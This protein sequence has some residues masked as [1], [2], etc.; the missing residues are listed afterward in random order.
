META[1]DKKLAGELIKTL[2][3]FK[4]QRLPHE[5][6]WQEQAEYLLP[7]REILMR[8]S[9]AKGMST[10]S[11]VFDGIGSHVVQVCAD[12]ILGYMASPV[13]KWNRSQVGR[14]PGV[15][16]LNDIP[17]IKKY[18]QEYDEAM[19][20]E[21]KNSGGNCGGFYQALGVLLRDGISIG[22][23][24]CFTTEHSKK[25]KLLY[26]VFH[27]IE[28]YIGVN[29]DGEVDMILREYD[30]SNRNALKYFGEAKLSPECVQAAK[31][32]PLKEFKILWII[33]PREERIEGLKSAKHMPFAAYYVDIKNSSILG[34]SG[35]ETMPIVAYRCILDS[36]ETYPR[37]PGSN[38]L[39]DIKMANRMSEVNI[40]GGQ[41][42][43]DRPMEAP[44]EARG[45][46]DLNPGGM[47]WRPSTIPVG[48]VQAIDQNIVVPFLVDQ[49]DRIEERIKKHFFYDFFLSLLLAEKQMTAFEVSQKMGE[50]ST[51]LAPI[52][53]RF[54]GDVLDRLIER[55]ALLAQKAGRLPQ[56]P[57]ILFELGATELDIEYLGPLYQA[58]RMLFKTHGIMSFLETIGQAAQYWPDAVTDRINGDELVEDLA[59]AHGMPEKDVRSD[60]EVKQIREQR[61]KI[62]QMMQ[63]AELAKTGAEAGQRMS[64]AP[65]PG[66]PMEALM[67]AGGVAPGGAA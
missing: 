31:D 28:M 4:K 13:Y 44:I 48:Q 52:I 10:E 30:I 35:F 23:G 7:N 39:K 36:G 1:A 61:A 5:P 67:G 16:D 57:D 26:H 41:K 38:A 12:G 66:S 51:V 24:Y 29:E 55:S 42:M 9:N 50:K 8:G 27:P 58:Q 3:L 19:Y 33:L 43:I 54:I 14:V 47:F 25:R 64:T 49:L 46:V 63:Q 32:H 21:F 60:E 17:E 20:A 22:P 53:Y 11:N 45:L 6:R 18:L 40:L 37:C 65:Q 59:N 15:P 62:Q 56:P 2:K 34:E